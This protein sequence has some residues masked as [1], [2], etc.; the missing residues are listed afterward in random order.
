MYRIGIIGCGKIAQVRHI[1]EYIASGR[2][3][4]AALY[5]INAERAAG[6][7]ERY[8]ARACSGID[9]LLDQK[10]DAVSICTANHTHAEYAVRAL[11][12]GMDVLCEKP[13]ATSL[14][15][16]QAMVDAAARS[17]RILMIGQNQRLTATHVKA[18]ELIR[19]GAIG[20]PLTFATRF[21]H[22]GPETW[23]VDPGRNTWFF[24]RKKA[25][26]GAMADLGIHKTD[27]ID[28]LLDDTVKAVSA[29]VT[30][31]DKRDASGSLIPVDDNAMCIYEMAGGAIGT[32]CAS[33][34]DY[35]CEDNSTRID[36]SEG[37]M[38]I[39]VDPAYSIVIERRDGTRELY[40]L[41]AIQTND[42]QTSS[43]VIDCF[44]DSIEKRTCPIDATSVLPAMKAVFAALESAST[45][46]RVEIEP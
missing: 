39:Y 10:L 41:D 42:N 31:I 2:A 30:T 20:R 44:L 38:K 11:D 27:L 43:G 21:A 45:G 40:E 1:P 37:V 15:D 8:G 23:S 25:V 26:M 29:S 33:W 22:C 9:E 24:D 3:E 5:D 7:A 35:G 34:T 12:K 4:M 32:M 16:C 19:S 36:G 18:H 17:G 28:F 13:M 6:L 46:R 14:E